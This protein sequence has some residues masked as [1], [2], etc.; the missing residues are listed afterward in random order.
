MAPFLLEATTCL[1]TLSFLLAPLAG[2]AQTSDEGVLTEDD[3]YVSRTEYD[4]LKQKFEQ[5]L[6][7]LKAQLRGLLEAKAAPKVVPSQPER[8]EP[9]KVPPVAAKP[10]QAEE[11]PGAVPAG[12]REQE[13]EKAKRNLDEFLRRQK[14]LFKPG[15]IQL[16]VGAS[17]SHDTSDEDGSVCIALQPPFEIGC[18]ST[19]GAE[20]RAAGTSF[21]AR[22][23]LLDDVELNVS[24]PFTFVEQELDTL[25]SRDGIIRKLTRS[26][27]NAGLSDVSGALRYAAW[28]EEGIRPEVVLALS[29]KSTTGDEDRRLGTGHW[30][31]GGAVTLIKTIDPVVLFGSLG[32]TAALER[33]GFDP[34]DQIPYS[35][36]LGFSLNDQLSVSAALAGSAV[37]RASFN[38]GEIVG[39]SQDV[40]TL[41][42]STTVQ[43]AKYLFVEPF[44]V[45][46]LTEESPD[47][48]AGINVPYRL[49]VG[50]RLPFH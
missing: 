28:H 29:A 37:R 24:V 42:F 13:A 43:V 47:F 41:Q 33:D 48:I 8:K 38:G 39:S 45:F 16:E 36:G 17:Y 3:R 50:L 34:G 7:A 5:E 35:F 4:K 18:I 10:A 26:R 22:Y 11:P 30:N 40:H 32:Y 14:V 46:G 19:P 9:A 1:L 49:P 23:G 44:V 20:V 21:T 25:A 6:A 15:E 2:A 31:V 12:D 27:S